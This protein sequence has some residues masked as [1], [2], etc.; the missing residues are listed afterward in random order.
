MLVGERLSTTKLNDINSVRVLHSV[1]KHGQF[2][3]DYPVRSSGVMQGRSLIPTGATLAAS[4]QQLKGHLLLCHLLRNNGR[5]DRQHN[6]PVQGISE[7]R[8]PSCGQEGAYSGFGNTNW[9]SML[10]Q[11][12]LRVFTLTVCVNS[13]LEGSMRRKD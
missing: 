10:K 6:G 2:V 13:L 4:S 1:K 7:A 5:R 11:C 8:Q 3:V 12:R 9:H